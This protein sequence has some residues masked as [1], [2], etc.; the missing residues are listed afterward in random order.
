MNKLLIVSLFAGFLFFGA[1]AKPAEAVTILPDCERTLYYIQGPD[2]N[3][4]CSPST[5]AGC[6]KL[7]V[8]DFYKKFTSEEARKNANAAIKTNR[9]C[10]FND[11]VQLFVNLSKWGLGILAVLGVGIIVWGGFDFIL[12]MGNQEKIRE[13]KQTIW[14]GVLGT[15][16]VLI[17]YIFVSFFVRMLNSGST[18]L[19]PG[20]DYARVFSGDRCTQ[21]KICG[22]TSITYDPEKKATGGC[23]DND[24]KE[25]GPIT[26][27]VSKLQQML[28]DLGCYGDAIDGCFGPN[29][30]N[31]LV[32]FQKKNAL[33]DP[34]VDPADYGKAT[35][36]TWRNLEDAF[37]GDRG[38]VGCAGP[39]LTRT[40]DVRFSGPQPELSPPGVSLGKGGTVTWKSP[41]DYYSIINFGSIPASSVSGDVSEVSGE[42]RV[43]LP[44]GSP[45]AK[46]V[47]FNESGKSYRYQ[48]FTYDTS[49]MPW[50]TLGI[51]SGVI[52]VP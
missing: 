8:E 35:D 12:A 22:K 47:T 42:M 51:V 28:A 23:R 32:D 49:V 52:V 4:L 44:G 37:A 31:A 11:F 16:I 25:K 45:V 24:D 33:V 3:I 50:I 5:G 13:G 43:V 15:F 18:T 41:G 48:L 34:V 46:N 17:A 10:G 27:D 29:S 39:L 9:Q 21:Y 30:K 36:Q 1:S 40:V 7:N 19:F 14:G 20:T 2:S 38:T 6:E 26:T